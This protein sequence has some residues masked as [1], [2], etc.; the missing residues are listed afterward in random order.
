MSREAQ[1]RI[2]ALFSGYVWNPSE[3]IPEVF[4]ILGT[5]CTT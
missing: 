5:E 3:R 2:A 4:F 1:N